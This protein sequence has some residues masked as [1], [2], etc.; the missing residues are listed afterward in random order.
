MIIFHIH[1]C[2]DIDRACLDVYH[3]YI[4]IHIYVYIYTYKYIYIYLDDFAIEDLVCLAMMGH[5]P[6]KIRC[7]NLC[8][9][10]CGRSAAAGG[11]FGGD[12][13]RNHGALSE[14]SAFG[15]LEQ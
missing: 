12:H 4:Y 13:E 11:A 15:H 1:I 14:P 3:V 8:W 2:I 9:M 7:R 5:G 10:C 6:T